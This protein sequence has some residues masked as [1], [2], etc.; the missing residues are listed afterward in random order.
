MANTETDFFTE[1]LLDFKEQE[2]MDNLSRAWNDFTRL[3]KLHP[4]EQ[5][6]FRR[7]IHVAQHIIMARPVR[8]KYIKDTN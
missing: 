5:D 1:K 3:E 8:R 6:E 7:A 4:D 2:V